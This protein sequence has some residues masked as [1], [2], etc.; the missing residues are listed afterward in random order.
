[1]THTLTISVQ[2]NS[3]LNALILASIGLP[4]KA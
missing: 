3:S 4:L 2:V 1:M